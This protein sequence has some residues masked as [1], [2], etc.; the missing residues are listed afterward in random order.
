VRL[1]DAEVGKQQRHRLDVIE[2][3]RSAWM[4]SLLG[5]TLCFAIVSLMS[6]CASTASSRSA[7]IQSTA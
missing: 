4:V 2:D 5:S 7:I 6:F 1:D 3:P